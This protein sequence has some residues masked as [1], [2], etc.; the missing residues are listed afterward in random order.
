MIVVVGCIGASVKVGLFIGEVGCYSGKEGSVSYIWMSVFLYQLNFI[1]LLFFF[2]YM[3]GDTLTLT[4]GFSLF[5][6]VGG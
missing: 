1:Y 6:D 3:E 5:G 4:R 2:F